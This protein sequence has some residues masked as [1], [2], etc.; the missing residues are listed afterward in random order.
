MELTFLGSGNAFADGGRYWSSFLAD[1]RFLFDSP[2]TLLAH[3]K[4]LNVPLTGIEVVFISHFHGDHFMGLPFLYLEYKFKTERRDDL[5]IVGPPGIEKK[6]EGFAEQCYPDVTFESSYGRRYVDAQPGADQ[7]VNEVSF[8][9]FKMN[10]VVDK[11]QCF[12]YR[13][14]VGDKTVAYTGDT[15]YTEEILALAEGADVLVV[16]CTYP[17]EPG[18]EHMGRDDLIR[19]RQRVAPQTTLILTHLG[20][21]PDIAGLDNVLVARDFATYRFD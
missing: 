20:A 21:D 5:F 12:G 13:V 3:L 6:I 18:P 2:P 7:F 16:D 19:I 9:A 4:R 17:D 15:M 14:H 8:R 1:G 11:L 10:H